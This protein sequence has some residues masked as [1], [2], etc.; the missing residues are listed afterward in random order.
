MATATKAA[1]SFQS[2]GSNSSGNVTTGAS[3]NLTTALEAGV[4]GIITN[5]GTGPS[6]GCDFIVEVSNDNNNWFELARATA[7]TTN[8]ASYHFPVHIPGWVMYARTKF[9]G[10]TGQSVIVVAQGSRVTAM[11]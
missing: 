9:T 4:V 3:V 6:V 2:N 1:I 8:S 11:G 5:G 10:N 7:G